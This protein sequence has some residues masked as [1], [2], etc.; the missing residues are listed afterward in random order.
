MLI[1]NDVR[2]VEMYEGNPGLASQVIGKFSNIFFM[3]IEI[4]GHYIANVVFIGV[5]E[6]AIAISIESIC[7]PIL[8]AMSD[9]ISVIPKVPTPLQTKTTLLKH[10]FSSHI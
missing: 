1:L 3:V 9:L 7:I 5:T 6:N 8:L 2:N 4:D 10:T